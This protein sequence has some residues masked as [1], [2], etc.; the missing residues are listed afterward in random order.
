[1]SVTPRVS[2]VIP[3][4]NEEE[5]IGE[6]VK[7][8][9]RELVSEVIVVDNGSTDKTA[10]IAKRAGARVVFEPI[11]GYGSACI[12]GIENL[13]NPQPDII[14]FMDGD[15]SD[16]PREIKKLVDPIERDGFDLVLG[17]R[18]LGTME[19]GALPLYSV[20]ANRFFALLVRML[21]GL[22]LSDIG[23][24]KAIRCSALI[25]LEMEDRGY[26][27][28]IEMVVKSAKRD[29]MVGEVPLSFRKRIGTSKV[30]GNFFA[31]LKA[32]TKIVYV[33]LKYSLKRS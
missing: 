25:S 6:V 11:K 26:G 9:P 24:F 22:S 31:S 23:S 12:S 20:Y 28:P 19:K 29:L 2:V 5:A 15:Y 8:I 33:I 16:D 14:V 30:T 10:E 18:L 3:A 17:S 27:F 32:G 21:Y 1:M 7:S 4:L 13:S